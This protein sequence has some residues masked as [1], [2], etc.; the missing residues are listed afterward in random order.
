[1]E[2]I[3]E[4]II[5]EYIKTKYTT[6]PPHSRISVVAE[7]NS[8]IYHLLKERMQGPPI[9]IESLSLKPRGHKALSEGY[10]VFYFTSILIYNKNY[11]IP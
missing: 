8:N 11:T 9:V 2:Q 7:V 10:Y 6:I 3:E 4:D 1:M 5:I